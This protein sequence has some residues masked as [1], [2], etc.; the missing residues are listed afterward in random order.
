MTEVCKANIADHAR[1]ISHAVF[2]VAKVIEQ[3]KLKEELENAAVELVAKAGEVPYVSFVPKDVELP[4]LPYVDRLINLVK[5]AEV[6]GEIKPVNAQV[7]AR[8]AAKLRMEIADSTGKVSEVNLEHVFGVESESENPAHGLGDKKVEITS[9][10][11]EDRRESEQPQPD[12]FV[13][14]Q[15]LELNQASSRQSAMLNFVKSLPN[16]CRM[17]DM[18]EHFPSVSERTIRNDLQTLVS[19]GFI[20]RFGAVQ[21]PFAYYRSRNTVFTKDQINGVGAA[22]ASDDLLSVT[23]NEDRKGG[24]IS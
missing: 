9:P 17:K 21:G 15:A 5:L 8:E 18:L 20:E 23:S 12:R 11:A 19:G 24:V 13:K 22:R 14:P 7:I 4:Y 1:E 6:I 10:V 3:P 16:G 2:R